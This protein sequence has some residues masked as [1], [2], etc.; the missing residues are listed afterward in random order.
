MDTQPSDGVDERLREVW[1]D[2]DRLHDE[3][4]LALDEGRTEELVPA[5]HRLREIDPSPVR[6][7][8]IL[9]L[10]L[11]TCADHVGAEKVLRE[12]LRTAGDDA[13]T[14]FNIAPLSAWRG[15]LDEV[16]TALSNAL[17]CDPDHAETLEW[18]YRHYRRQQGR[19]AAVAWLEEQARSGWRAVVMLG[20]LAL[21]HGDEE[22]AMGLFAIACNRAPS[23]PEPLTIVSETLY[24]SERL[25]E[26]IDFVLQRWRGSHGPTPLIHVVEAN[27]RLGRPGDAALGLSR[28]RGVR[29]SP[30][31]FEHMRD[32]EAR[33]R[34]ACAEAGI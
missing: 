14:W 19:E 24:A 9:A 30:E 32:L 3:I 22:D 8:N 34:D 12:H 27:L 33:V 7:T 16:G 5:A 15:A 21:Q 29:I 4:R 13:T 1:D 25:S 23:H 10:V 26:V 2:S 17:R 11:R 18:G 6:S 28:L 31:K 20:Q